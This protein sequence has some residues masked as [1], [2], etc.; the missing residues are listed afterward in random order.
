MTETR[1]T[2]ISA[3]TSTKDNPH[4]WKLEMQAD[5]ILEEDRFLTRATIV[6]YQWPGALSSWK[7][8]G[9]TLRWLTNEC[10]AEP[11]I[12]PT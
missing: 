5:R 2:A 7:S 10:W 1:A 3:G 11:R 4:T 9:S 12:L 8:S 6:P